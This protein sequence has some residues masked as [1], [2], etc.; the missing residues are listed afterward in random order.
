M[1]LLAAGPLLVIKDHFAVLRRFRVSEC[2][3]RWRWQCGL[4]L[5]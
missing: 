3:E 4:R 1:L 5:S 2:R